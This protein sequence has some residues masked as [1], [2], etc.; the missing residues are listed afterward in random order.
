M[1][2]ISVVIDMTHG[3]IH[4]PQLTRQA[5]SAVSEANAKPQSVLTD[6]TLTKPP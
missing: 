4:F 2:D 3:L 6:D 1:R 5:K